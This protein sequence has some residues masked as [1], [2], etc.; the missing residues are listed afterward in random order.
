MLGVTS[1]AR[2]L[3]FNLEVLQFFGMFILKYKK[4]D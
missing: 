1:L 3:R 4:G 2:D